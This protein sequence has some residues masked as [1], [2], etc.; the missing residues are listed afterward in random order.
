MAC[1]AA[2]CSE[3]QR[4]R[5]PPWHELFSTMSAVFLALRGAN[6]HTVK[7]HCLLLEPSFFVT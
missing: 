4:R 7:R 1:F 5:Q 6:C 2:A 3:L